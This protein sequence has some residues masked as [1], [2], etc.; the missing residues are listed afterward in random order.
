M[1]TEQGK[2]PVV[3]TKKHIARLER[4][5][6]QTRLIL[7]TFIAIMLAVIGLLGYGFLDLYYLQL[8]RPV[9]KAGDAEITTKDFE[10]RV[11]LQRQQLLDNYSFY[12][13]YQQFGL[14]VTSQL[15][16]IQSQLDDPV[17]IGQSCPTPK[18]A[19]NL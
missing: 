15:Q 14:D 2:K 18:H 4:E 5:R 6:R 17:T 1:P 16:Q 12:L 3:H 11:R 9:A 13:Q 8:Q 10:A 7:Y 19:R